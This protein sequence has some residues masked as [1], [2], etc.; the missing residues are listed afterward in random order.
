MNAPILYIG[1]SKGGVSKSSLA[2]AL[3]DY[4]IAREKTSCCWKPTPPI[5]MSTKRICRTKMRLWSA[6]W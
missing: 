6:S 5:L 3:V 4:L 2:F 1:G